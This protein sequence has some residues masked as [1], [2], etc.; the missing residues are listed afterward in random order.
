MKEGTAEPEADFV[1]GGAQGVPAAGAGFRARIA[2]EEL[3]LG[4]AG[5]EVGEQDRELLDGPG[6]WC[7]LDPSTK[8]RQEPVEGGGGVFQGECGEPGSAMLD[9]RFGAELPDSPSSATGM[10]E[11]ESE[12]AREGLNEEFPLRHRRVEGERLDDGL[13]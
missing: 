9:L 5:R 2:G 13:R 8:E 6:E 7:L 11:G 3:Q 10:G 12:N 1:G 4:G